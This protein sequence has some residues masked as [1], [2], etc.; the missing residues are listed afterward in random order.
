[1]TRQNVTDGPREILTKKCPTCEG[2]GIVVSEATAAMEV[3]RR[4]RTLAAGSRAQAFKVEVN[5]RT[6]ALLIGPGA[7]RLTEIEAATKK[8]FFFV[9]KEGSHA[10]HVAVL[11]EGKLADLQPEAPVAEGAEV[12]LKLVELARHDAQSAAGKLDGL[13]VVVAGAAKLVGK[14]AKVRIER[15]LDGSAYAVLIS[16]GAEPATAITFES[17]AEKPTRAPGRRKTSDDLQDVLGEGETEAE[18]ALEPDAALEPEAEIEGEDDAEPDAAESVDGEPAVKKKTRRGS[19]GGRNRKKKPAEGANGAE[20]DTAVAADADADEAVE[21]AAADT[22]PKRKAPRIHV[23]DFDRD[24]AATPKPRAR[25]QT[26]VA[27]EVPQE[28][29]SVSENGAGAED[30]VDG[31][32]VKK[33]TRRG[34]RGGRNRKKKPPV[35]EAGENG[36]EA[37]E[38]EVAEAAEAVEPEPSAEPASK[39]AP[40]AGEPR[41]DEYVPMSEWLDEIEA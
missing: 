38:P 28:V 9:G 13:E 40:K 16:G 36:A 15:V 25:T 35:A 19:R 11:E 10:D 4:L 3:E 31:E 33:K 21:A 7:A 30:A 39:P 12:E 20:P 2:D 32:P 14:K 26:P 1:M 8:R 17:E 29:D 34:S 41:S 6:A 22:E 37:A 27:T 18:T 5:P 23:P 24:E